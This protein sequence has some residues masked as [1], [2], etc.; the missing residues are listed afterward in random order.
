[1]NNYIKNI[2][3]FKFQPPPLVYYGQNTQYDHKHQILT[4]NYGGG[5]III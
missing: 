5:S 2:E 1:M 3:T 4:V